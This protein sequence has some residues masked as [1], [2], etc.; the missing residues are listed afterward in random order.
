MGLKR[1]QLSFYEFIMPWD[2]KYQYLYGN[3]DEILEWK[4]QVPNFPVQPHPFTTSMPVRAYSR[5]HI[6][7]RL[8]IFENFLPSSA[9]THFSIRKR[10]TALCTSLSLWWEYLSWKLKEES[11]TQMRFELSTDESWESWE[12]M[13]GIRPI[14]LE[15]ASDDCVVSLRILRYM[16]KRMVLI[17]RVFSTHEVLGHALLR[18]IKPRFCLILL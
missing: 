6:S 17:T 4:S 14:K 7:P 11:W 2:P 15:M 8:P 16:C 13:E 5:T 10:E 3:A 18:S 12:Y 9:E 1:V